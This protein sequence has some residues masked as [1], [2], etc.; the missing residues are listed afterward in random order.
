MDTPDF[1]ERTHKATEWG[2]SL[3]TGPYPSGFADA[4]PIGSVAAQPEGARVCTAGRVMRL[5]EMGRIAFGDLMDASG[6]LQFSLDP[7]RLGEAFAPVLRLLDLGDIVGIDGELYRTRHGELTVG[8][9]HIALL[10]KALRPLP[11]KWHGLV[12][13]ELQLRDRTLDLIAHEDVRQRFVRRAA[14]VRAIRATL[15]EAGFLEVETPILQAAASGAAARPFTTHHH[16]LDI[17]LHLRVAPETY[18]KRVVAGG[19][20]RVYELGRNFRNEGL[21][22]THLQEFTMLE[23]YAAYWDCEASIP[24]IEDLV[25]RAVHATK[26]NCTI[27]VDGTSFDLA[28]PWRRVDYFEL[29]EQGTGIDLRVAGDVATLAEAAARRGLEVGADAARTYGTLV[30]ALYKRCCR[31]RLVAP[32]LLMD[33]P[34]GLAPLARRS[35][36]QPR[37]LEMYQLAVGGVE[38]VKAYGELVDPVEQRMRLLEQARE[39]ER[40]DPEAMMMDE[41]F[42]RAMEHAMPPMTGVGLGIDRLAMLALGTRS[43][44]DVVLFPALRP[45]PEPREAGAG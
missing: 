30:D 22:P 42:L 12:D 41:P 32:T 2:R 26:G 31:P 28:R 35:D 14:M 5:R 24:F 38:I 4:A 15:D 6:T 10:A 43:I 16:A 27:E 44:R 3:G 36:L 19:F 8:V 29:F 37:R 20:D 45:H 25:R 13:P 18:L 11:E 34:V 23:F 40:G 21:D 17:D 1:I 33:P 39:H 7:S 9:S